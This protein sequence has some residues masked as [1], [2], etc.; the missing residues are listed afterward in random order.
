MRVVV[1]KAAE[2]DLEG[3]G[4]WIAEDNPTRAVTFIRELRACC[5]E[6]AHM[7][8]AFPLVPRYERT[9]IRRRPYRDYL[10]FYRIR[11]KVIDILHVVHGARDYE[12][13]LF[14]DG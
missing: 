6:L 10:I 8:R 4:D 11:D 12:V 3:I 9:G 2:A 5:E 7:P 1:S 13:L 14:P